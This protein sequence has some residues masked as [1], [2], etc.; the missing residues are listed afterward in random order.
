MERRMEN[1][2]LHSQEPRVK[3]HLFGKRAIRKSF[4]PDKM[5]KDRRSVCPNPIA[6]SFPNG[7]R[8]ASSVRYVPGFFGEFRVQDAG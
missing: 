8:F 3:M 4:F 6:L 2:S 7:R 5:A 1:P